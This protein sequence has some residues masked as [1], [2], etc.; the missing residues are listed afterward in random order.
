M[1]HVTPYDNVVTIDITHVT[2]WN[3]HIRH[4]SHSRHDTSHDMQQAH[5]TF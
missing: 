3:K 1:K 2:T 4:S 5:L